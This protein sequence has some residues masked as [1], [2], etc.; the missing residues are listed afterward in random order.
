MKKSNTC[1]DASHPKAAV[2]KWFSRK[3]RTWRTHGFSWIPNFLHPGPGWLNFRE[4]SAVLPSCYVDRPT[5]RARWVSARLAIRAA[6]PAVDTDGRWC[7]TGTTPNRITPLPMQGSLSDSPP[8]ALD[9]KH[10]AGHHAV[11]SWITWCQPGS[12]VTCKTSSQPVSKCAVQ[13]SPLS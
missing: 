12:L 6:T 2:T 13:Q 11:P 3:A 5:R 4:T 9:R 10:N 8:S 7:N 1:F